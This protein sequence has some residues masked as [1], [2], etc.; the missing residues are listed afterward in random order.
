MYWCAPSKNQHKA[1]CQV[2]Q[3]PRPRH[4]KQRVSVKVHK[5]FDTK[6]E[7]HHQLF[8]GSE[9]PIPEESKCVSWQNEA[10]FFSKC[11]QPCAAGFEGACLHTRLR[12]T[13]RFWPE[14]R[15]RI[16]PCTRRWWLKSALAKLG[17]DENRRGSG[18][19]VAGRPGT[20]PGWAGC[21][22][23]VGYYEDGGGYIGLVGAGTQDPPR[24]SLAGDCQDS[25]GCGVER[26]R[27][28]EADW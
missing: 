28:A 12:V 1:G 11:E 6:L 19:K 25:K 9:P 2:S 10:R 3:I 15:T 17:L 16:K 18:G 27:V 24:S 7:C 4:D 14:R 8:P 13:C 26:W 5:F 23:G 22:A 20:V 21:V